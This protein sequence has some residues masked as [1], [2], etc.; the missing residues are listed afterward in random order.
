MSIKEFILIM[1]STLVSRA[2]WLLSVVSLVYSLFCFF[3]SDSPN[4]FLFGL[5]GVVSFFIGYGLYKFAITYIYDE[6]DHYK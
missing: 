4:R 5:L 1:L 2:G 6:S 3:V